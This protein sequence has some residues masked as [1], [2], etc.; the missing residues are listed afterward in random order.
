MEGNLAPDLLTF[1]MRQMF[2][3]LVA[4]LIQVPLL[5][6]Q[7]HAS[8]SGESPLEAEMKILHTQANAYR[9]SRRLKPLTRRAELDAIAQEHADRMAAGKVSFS[10][11]GFD[12]RAR[13]SRKV[14]PVNTVGENL[15]WTTDDE[16]VGASAVKGWIKSKGHHANLVGRFTYCG[17]GIAMDSKGSFYVVQIYAG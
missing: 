4:C 2:V 17:I 6:G 1:A 7:P 11:T 9:A 8:R 10:H 14:L 5:S 16:E 3:L 15:Y 12:A 13:Q